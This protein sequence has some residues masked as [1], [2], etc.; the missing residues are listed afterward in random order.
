MLAGI[1]CILASAG[2]IV[3]V[4]GSSSINL[5]VYNRYYIGCAF[6]AALYFLLEWTVSTP[7][8]PKQLVSYRCGH[9]GRHLN[10]LAVDF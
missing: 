4:R 8:W 2:F 1:C 7:G 9:P 10:S 3:Q 5:V 6:S